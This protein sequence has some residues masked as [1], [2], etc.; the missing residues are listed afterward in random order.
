M[1]KRLT[2]TMKTD[3]DLLTTMPLWVRLL[4]FS[5]NFWSPKATSALISTIRVPIKINKLQERELESFAHVL[6]EVK[7]E[8]SFPDKVKVIDE[9]RTIYTQEIIYENPHPL[10]DNCQCFGHVKNQCP[11]IKTWVP[12]TS[13]EKVENASKVKVENS[14]S[15][16]KVAD[17][18][19]IFTNQVKP[20][21]TW[22][23]KENK[24][25]SENLEISILDLV[26]S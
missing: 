17:S 18:S 5:F 14:R 26:V 21:T 9:S 24:V 19:N 7:A 6:V 20:N 8:F 22:E 10:C 12:K 16:K 15:N 3:R 4:D 2:P 23:T 1:M 13:Q 25:N 11:M